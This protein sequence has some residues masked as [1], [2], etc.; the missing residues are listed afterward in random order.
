MFAYCNNN[1]VMGCDPCGTCVHNWKFYNCEKCDA[2]WNGVGGWF[3][4]AYDTITSVN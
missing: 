1:P 3:V 4:D 2:F